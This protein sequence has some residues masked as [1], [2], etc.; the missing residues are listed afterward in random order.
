MFIFLSSQATR[1]LTHQVARFGPARWVAAVFACTAESLVL[2][3][4]LGLLLEFG[5][6]ANESMLLFLFT[7]P[8]YG[9]M[10]RIKPDVVH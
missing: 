3:A 1:W 5:E 7:Y 2:C 9:V 10:L 4:N 8:D 6:L